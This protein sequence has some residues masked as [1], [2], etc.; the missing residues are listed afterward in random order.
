MNHED[1]GQH[2]IRRNIPNLITSGNLICGMLALLLTVRGQIIP[3]GW[4]IPL[5]VV[6]D[7]SDGLVARRLGVNSDFGVEF[8]SLGDLI[9][10][11]VAPSVMVYKMFFTRYPEAV[12]LALAL[13]FPLCGAFRLARFNVSTATAEKGWFTGLPI[14]SAGL[15]LTGC[16]MINKVLPSYLVAGISVMCGLLMVSSIPYGN[17]KGV[18]RDTANRHRILALTAFLVVTLTLARSA[19]LFA[20]AGLYV[21]SGLLN[22][23]WSGWLTRKEKKDAVEQQDSSR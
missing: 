17:L 11:G 2:L 19:G 4:M 10:F 12:A 18:S 5:A 21:I 8:D 23:N 15:W 22:F 7:F 14:P 9:S 13:F 20:L 1:T 6:F 3:A 16:V